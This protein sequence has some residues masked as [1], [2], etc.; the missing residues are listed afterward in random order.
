[1]FVTIEEV[2]RDVDKLK[3]AVYGNGVIGHKQR[4]EKLEQLLEEKCEPDNCIGKK[5]LE[6]YMEMAQEK[7][8][9]IK[10]NENERSR[11]RRN[12]LAILIAAIGS[13]LMPIILKIFWK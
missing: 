5:A 11:F 8:S 7:E 6:D 13:I 9:E 4:I 2:S 10:A 1:V 3:V 12:D